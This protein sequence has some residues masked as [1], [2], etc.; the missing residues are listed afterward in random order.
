VLGAGGFGTVVK[1]RLGAGYRGPSLRNILP[2]KFALKVSRFG[3]VVPLHLP[4]KPL[5]TEWLRQEYRACARL[6]NHLHILRAY[7]GGIAVSRVRRTAEAPLPVEKCGSTVYSE[8]DRLSSE[9]PTDSNSTDGHANS[10]GEGLA[11]SGGGGEG[12]GD[13]QNEDVWYR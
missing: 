8:V 7:S 2:S 13:G 5:A 3:S 9:P 10:E 1:A 6:P 11:I 12:G 4:Q